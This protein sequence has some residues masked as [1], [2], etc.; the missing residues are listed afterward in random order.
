LRWSFGRWAAN[1]WARNVTLIAAN[2]DSGACLEP[3]EAAIARIKLPPPSQALLLTDQRLILD[4]T[5]L[6]RHTNV[7]ACFWIDR[8][9]VSGNQLK[10]EKYHR[11]ILEICHD[12][13]VVLE[14][15][16]QAVFPLLKFFWF[17]LGCQSFSKE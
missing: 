3:M 16:G 10:R 6:V 11:I 12:R 9:K 17:H 1:G 13:E 2:A 7:T 15:L 5:T 8:K 4:S 14:G